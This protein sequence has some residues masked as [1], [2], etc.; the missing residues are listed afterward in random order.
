MK[1]ISQI[2]LF[3]WL[4]LFTIS[5][6]TQP[7]ENPPPTEITYTLEGSRLQIH[8]TDGYLDNLELPCKGLNVV[9]T[10]DTLYVA[11]GISGLLIIDIS[12]PEDPAIKGL[13]ELGGEVRNVFS[14][15]DRTWAEVIRV[16]AFPVDAVVVTEPSPNV[17]QVGP[18]EDPKKTTPPIT[19]TQ[20]EDTAFV[21]EV[22]ELKPGAVVIS[23]GKK[24]RIKRNDR[25]ELFIEEEISLG[26]DDNLGTKETLIAIG[27]VTTV[28]DE[29]SEVKLGIN[30]RVPLN[31]KARE[32]NKE[33][34]SS[35]VM[36]PRIGGNWGLGFALRP[37]LPLDDLG[38]GTVSDAFIEYH[39][40]APLVI[41]LLIEPLGIG[42]AGDGN[43]VSIAGNIFAAYDTDAF[44]IG[45]GIGWTA[46]NSEFTSSSLSSSD[47]EDGIDTDFDRVQSGLS[48]IQVARLGSKDGLHLSAHN[49]F[50]LYNDDFYYGGTRGTIQIPLG[51]TYTW[52]I[53]QGGGGLSGYGFGEIGLRVLLS[54]NGDSDSLF[55]TPSLGGAVLSG[56]TEYDCGYTTEETCYR[57]VTY[58]GPM[59][60]FSVEWRL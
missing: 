19:E 29:R 6:Q 40:N 11:C 21:G 50:I 34:T 24:N 18:P 9:R 58:G 12:K 52:L 56:E 8:L 44:Q 32:T 46:V 1:K 57:D 7:Q 60:G 43:V 14:A 38:I 31:A 35:H 23:L 28:T 10:E 39:F 13:R 20:L 27:R 16:Q 51:R 45:L 30:E 55:V 54:G 49:T 59:I 53:L 37:F 42:F 15:G 36:P 25:V 33:L 4:I 47:Y 17:I 41:G 22:W 3:C 26:G 2:T 48:I 5:G